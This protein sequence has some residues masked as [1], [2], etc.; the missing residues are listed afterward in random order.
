METSNF[1]VV[2]HGKRRETLAASAVM[3]IF[4]ALKAFEHIPGE[5]P[6]FADCHVGVR[7]VAL[8]LVGRIHMHERWLRGIFRKPIFREVPIPY[9]N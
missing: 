2:C 5:I 9:P 7:S 4:P 3:N 1:T 8:S 6:S